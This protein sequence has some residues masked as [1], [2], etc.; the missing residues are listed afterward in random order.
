MLIYLFSWIHLVHT[1]YTPL[2]G[3]RRGPRLQPI[4]PLPPNL[5]RY[6]DSS[7]S[8]CR[9]HL[10]TFLNS[11]TARCPAYESLHRMGGVF[12]THATPCTGSD[13]QHCDAWFHCMV[14][15]PY[16]GCSADFLT[17]Q[18]RG[19]FPLKCTANKQPKFIHDVNGPKKKT[20]VK[21]MT[22][23]ERQ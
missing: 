4:N 5:D 9:N 2:E 6:F 3:I 19:Q 20:Y 13:K 1:G 23:L 11:N 18:L 16:K 8:G 22:A 21:C 10:L 7:H 15:R 12:S 14:V 17:E